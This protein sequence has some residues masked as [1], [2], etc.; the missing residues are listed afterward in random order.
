MRRSPPPWRGCRRSRRRHAGRGGRRTGG[1]SGRPVSGPSGEGQKLRMVT[2]L[3]VDCGGGGSRPPWSTTPTRC[4]ASRYGCRRRTHCRRPARR[5]A[6]RDRGGPAGRGPG[7]GRAAGD[8]PARGGRRDAALR[9]RGRA[10]QPVDPE[11]FALWKGFDA[12]A[13]LERAFGRPVLVLNDAEVHGAAL[14]EGRGLEL[15]LTLGTGLGSALFDGG[16]LAPHLELSH[17]P[18]SKSRTYDDRSANW[19]A[20]GS[21]T[22]AGRGGC[23]GSWTGCGR[24]ST[25]TGCTWAAATPSGSSWRWRTTYA[26]C[27]TRPGCAAV[28]VPGR[29]SACKSR[30]VRKEPYCD[31]VTTVCDDVLET[32]RGAVAALRV[33]PPPAVDTGVAVVLCPGLIGSKE[34]FLPLL[35][36][37]AAAG[38]RAYAYDYRGHYDAAGV[39]DG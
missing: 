23:C 37:L 3:T 16:R 2:T 7:H 24:C 36:A 1:L 12:R 15:V 27:R 30:F 4:A 34:D 28:P 29:S 20:G 6:A 13:D 21:A 8:D 10:A 32:A 33:V 22:G 14:V 18:Y 38:Y 25:G 26:S 35:P 31:A 5:D 19:S 17:A 39:L 9:Q 11:L